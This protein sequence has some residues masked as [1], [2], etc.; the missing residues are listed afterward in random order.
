MRTAK[1]PIE[2]RVGYLH[3]EIP[4]ESDG[5]V[6][7]LPRKNGALSYGDAVGVSYADQTI[8]PDSEVAK[9][10]IT[11]IEFNIQWWSWSS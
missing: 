1:H 8:V 2:K 3:P 7:G 11:N 5:F 10:S 9:P 6:G 4:I